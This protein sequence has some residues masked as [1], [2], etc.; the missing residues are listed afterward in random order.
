MNGT[1]DTDVTTNQNSTDCF[2]ESVD[3]GIGVAV[4]R[5]L[6]LV[7]TGLASLQSGTLA[8]GTSLVTLTGVGSDKVH[9]LGCTDDTKTGVTGNWLH[10]LFTLHWW[11]R[12]QGLCK[13]AFSSR[14]L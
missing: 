5:T 4:I 10:C 11:A 6:V 2:T 8:G 14:P 12:D 1:T 13:L 3:T 7:Y 9:V